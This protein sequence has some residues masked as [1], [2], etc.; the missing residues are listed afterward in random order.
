MAVQAIHR[1]QT[2]EHGGLHGI[3]NQAALDT[4]LNRLRQRW[5]HGELQSIPQLAAAYTE[6]ILRAH[7]FRD[8]NKRS[9]F[10]VAVVFLGLNG[11]L[12]QASNESVVLMIQR[13]AVGELTWSDLER[14]FLDH[15]VISQ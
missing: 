14:W 7:H 15:S 2:L 10:L 12:F 13:L 5:S 6:A 11:F 8:G 4:A 1:Q 3:R 9:S